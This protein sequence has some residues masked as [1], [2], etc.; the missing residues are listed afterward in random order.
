MTRIFRRLGVALLWIG[1]AST[2]EAA[3]VTIAWDANPEPE[4]S[5][6]NVFVSTNPANMGAP[7]AV[8]NRLNWTFLNLSSNATYYFGVQ[9]SSSTG[10]L[11]PI[12]IIGHFTPAPI[13]PGSERSRSDFNADGL[14][15]VIW[16]HGP[17]GQLLA[18]HM[19]GAGVLASRYFNPDRAGSGW[20][21]R[22]TGDFNRDGKPDLIW[23]HSGTGDLAVWLMD[24]VLMYG[25]GFLNPSRVTAPWQL[26]SIRDFNL[27]GNPDLIWHNQTTGQL[28]AWFMSGSVATA[29]QFFTPSGVAD[30]NYKLKGTADFSGDGR[31][32]ILWHNETNGDLRIWTMSGLTA[33][34][35]FSVMFNGSPV[36]VGPPWKIVAV[37]DANLDGAPDIFWENNTTGQVVVWAM[38]GANLLNAPSI[39]TV[40]PAWKIAAPR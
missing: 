39:G 18:W 32:D 23:H 11:S 22:G 21:L 24:G 6:Y 33:T 31:P 13:P 14:F 5:G 26:A 36:Y 1:M 2:V 28:Q 15:D 38:S 16:Q 37:G 25:V 20:I 27:D 17:T 30:T 9:A 8:G 7:T 40:D 12:A 29:A 35:S 4:V 19:N 3:T 34:G 10:A